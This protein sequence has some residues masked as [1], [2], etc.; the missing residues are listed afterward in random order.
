MKAFRREGLSHGASF[1][2]KVFR[3]TRI[4][5][6]KTGGNATCL[7]HMFVIKLLPSLKEVFKAL[8]A[9]SSRR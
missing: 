5:A 9:M 2:K 6:G 7:G 3:K 4:G 8:K 1:I